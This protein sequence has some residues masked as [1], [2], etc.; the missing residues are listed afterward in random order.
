MRLRNLLPLCLLLAALLAPAQAH[1]RPAVALS[2]NTVT[3]LNDSR[4]H[5]TGIKRVRKL[6]PYDDVVRGGRRL[7][8]LD[9]WFN[10]ARE[11]GIEPLVS[12]YRSY[13]GKK[14]IPTVAGY[15][16]YFRAFRS[17]TPG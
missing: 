10:T 7:A 15:R 2:D 9:H 1:A 6:V 12:F 4:F 5:A 13:R 11:R 14:R 17:A 3:T 16:K 8:A